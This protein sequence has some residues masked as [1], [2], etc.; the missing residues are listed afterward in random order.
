MGYGHRLEDYEGLG[1][2]IKFY[3]YAASIVLLGIGIIGGTWW[4]SDPRKRSQHG[5]SDDERLGSLTQRVMK[6]AEM[7]DKKEGL[8]LEDFANLAKK[9][10]YTEVI[11][12]LSN[13]E[14]GVYSDTT[15]SQNSRYVG[16][17]VNDKITP[18]SENALNKFLKN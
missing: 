17:K 16:I 9:L 6:K 12:E 18:I 11:S 3:S 10:G 14:L 5:P 8:S 13:Y 1:G 4:S 15:W 2:K 7:F